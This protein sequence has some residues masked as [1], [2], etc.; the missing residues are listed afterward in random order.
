MEYATNLFVSRKFTLY[1]PRNAYR[2][3]RFWLY[4]YL[5]RMYDVD[6]SSQKLNLVS[7]AELELG[8]DAPMTIAVNAKVKSQN[9]LSVLSRLY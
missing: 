4:R 2:A 5:Q 7:E 3:S 9:A 6:K 1:S 8:E